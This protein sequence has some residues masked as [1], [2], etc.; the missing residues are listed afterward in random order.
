MGAPDPFASFGRLADALSP[1]RATSDALRL[2]RAVTDLCTSTVA[3]ACRI[4]SFDDE[5]SFVLARSVTAGRLDLAE[6]SDDL[7][8]VERDASRAQVHRDERR[9]LWWIVAPLV[10][11]RD[12][13]GVMRL[14]LDTATAPSA[15][16]LAAVDDIA[17]S[18][19]SGLFEAQLHEHDSSVSQRL[20]LSLLRR[21]LPEA[22]W[23]RLA[24]RYVPATAGMY[25]GGDWFDGQMLEAGELALSV[26]DVAGHGVDAAARMGEIRSAV[27]ALR[28]LS[29]APDDLIMFLHGMCEVTGTFATSICV[30]LDTTGSLRWASAGHLPPLVA[31]TN[32]DVDVL[33]GHQSP[34]L[35]T[36]YVRSVELNRDALAPGDTLLMYTDGLVE[37]R[38][39]PID[40]SLR[41]LVGQVVS[42]PSKEPALLV[43]HVVRSRQDSGP[44]SD[45]IAVLAARYARGAG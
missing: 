39:E 2:G 25:V 42:S 6:P 13:L 45:D 29:R 18:V 14:A 24:A 7:G 10:T 28:L 5:G 31:R 30:R 41:R 17:A 26:G 15:A 12:M 1:L 32:G 11:G 44:T 34:P 3:A 22:E 21:S 27:L 33:E 38:D 9:R 16:E 36:G 8:V 37:R 4:D 35:G 43:D 20:Q 40:E 23:F 19:A